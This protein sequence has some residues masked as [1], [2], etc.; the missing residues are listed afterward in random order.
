MTLWYWEMQIGASAMPVYFFM[1]ERTL[2]LCL[3]DFCE[4]H[5]LY[6][7]SKQGYG[8]STVPWLCMPLICWLLRRCYMAQ[9][10]S[11]P[12]SILADRLTH[13]IRLVLS[14]H[15]EWNHYSGVEKSTVVWIWAEP[16]MPLAIR[17]RR[18][19]GCVWRFGLGFWLFGLGFWCLVV[20]VLGFFCGF[21]SGWVFWVCFRYSQRLG[22]GSICCSRTFVTK[23]RIYNILQLNKYLCDNNYILMIQTGWSAVWNTSV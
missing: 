9:F 19:S 8:L 14:R 17:R 10:W 11:M 4:P 15:G 1:C 22:L 3:L 6:W 12:A 5:W 13:E 20:L 21:A 2:K 7:W 23:G 18:E 16:S